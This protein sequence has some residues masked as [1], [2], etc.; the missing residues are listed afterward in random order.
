MNL[1]QF[2]T[3]GVVMTLCALGL[4]S[5][6]SQPSSTRSPQKD[7][8]VDGDGQTSTIDCKGGAVNISGDDN[9]ITLMNECSRLMVTGDDNTVKAETVAQIQVLGDDNTIVVQAVGRINTTGDDNTVT[10]TR[11]IGGKPPEISNTGDDNKTTQ[12]R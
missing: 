10:W 2:A 6:P 11:G 4:L 7:I 9:T 12:A 5:S 1:R 8:A 3:A